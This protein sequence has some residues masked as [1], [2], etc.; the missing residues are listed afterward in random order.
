MAVDADESVESKSKQKSCRPWNHSNE[1]KEAK[2]LRKAEG[3]NF[4]WVRH[5][6]RPLPHYTVISPVVNLRNNMNS[7]NVAFRI[8]NDIKETAGRVWC[9]ST[10]W[11]RLCR[12]HRVSVGSEKGFVVTVG[13]HKRIYADTDL[14][15]RAPQC[16]GKVTAV[17]CPAVSLLGMR[18][19]KASP[20]VCLS[21]AGS[22]SYSITPLFFLS[23]SF[24]NL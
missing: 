18:S 16:Q 9:F 1:L 11:W 13:R 23:F 7:F 14:C 8:V 2:P 12:C 22:F 19:S 15:W 20:P 10:M 17:L 4:P 24:T 5:Y 6:G 3:D 21:F